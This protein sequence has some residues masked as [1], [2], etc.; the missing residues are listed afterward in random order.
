MSLWDKLI[1]T[2]DE[3]PGITPVSHVSLPISICVLLDEK[4]KLLLIDRLD[5][6]EY[7]ISPCTA[8][9]ETRTCN[10]CPHVLNDKMDYIG[11]SNI[12]K[13]KLYMEHLKEYADASD[14]VY[15]VAIYNYLSKN[16]LEKDLEN[17]GLC[18]NNNDYV[19]FSVLNWIYTPDEW[20]DFYL[21]TL[22]QSGKCIL[23]QLDDYIPSAY[24]AKIRFPADK[25]KLFCS[26]CGVGYIASQ[27]IIHTLQFLF[28]NCNKLF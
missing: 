21:E 8:Q 13:H 16:N 14:Y 22:P 28:S 15:P 26:G 18:Y 7:T 3:M 17:N 2:Y 24:P 20:T 6:P 10:P 9:S 27:K 25:A 5:V 11:C 12:I 1:E 23:T 4:G 19:G